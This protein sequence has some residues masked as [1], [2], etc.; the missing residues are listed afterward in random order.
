MDFYARVFEVID[1][2]SFSNLWYW[3]GLAVF[4]SSLSYY[5]LGVPWDMIQRARRG[6][7]ERMA[8]DVQDLVRVNVNRLLMI[9][10]VSGLLAL[11]F[12]AF[13]MTLLAILAFWYGVEFAQAVFFIAAPGAAV[14]VLAVNRAHRIANEQAVGEVLYRHLLHHRRTVQAIGMASIFVTAMFGMYQN[15]AIG[16]WG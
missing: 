14:G 3:I 9:G 13:A 2:R 5:V 1:M 4:W 12:A 7:E 16:A 11:W 6:G 8:A 15:L 10:R